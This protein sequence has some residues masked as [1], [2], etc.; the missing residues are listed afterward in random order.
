LFVLV[1]D[2]NYEYVETGQFKKPVVVRNL[3]GLGALFPKRQN[4][5]AEAVAKLLGEL[6][7]FF[8]LVT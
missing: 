3:E 2:F 6:F 1:V 4:F 8:F 7:Y 5:T